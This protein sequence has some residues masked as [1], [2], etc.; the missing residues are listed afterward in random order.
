VKALSEQGVKEVVL[1]GQNVNGYHDTSPQSAELFPTS[2]YQASSGFN[3]LYRSKKRDLPGARFADLLH[4][5]ADVDENMRVRFTSPHPK[6]FPPEALA[7]VGARAN[8]CNA[9]HLPAQSGSTSV[10]V[11]MRRGYSRETF[12]ALVAEVRQRIPHVSIST[13]IISGFCGEVGVTFHKLHVIIIG[14]VSVYMQYIL[15]NCV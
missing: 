1:L 8:I 6:D 13:D 15:Y 14:V 11:R 9:L 12:L 4:S 3:N 5:I 7:A 10:L 2:T